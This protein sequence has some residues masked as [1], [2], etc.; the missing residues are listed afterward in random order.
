MSYYILFENEGEIPINAFK[1]L[2]ASSKR[3][4]DTKIG[5][6]G[7]GLKYAIALMLREGIDFKIFSGTKE[8]RIGKRQTKFLD[9]KIYVMTVNDEKTSITLDA[10][11]DW[12]PWFAIREIYSNTIDEGGKM[13]LN[14]PVEPVA[15][16]TRI[17]I[18]SANLK[19]TDIMASWGDFFTIGRVVAEKIE[20][21]P[22]GRILEKTETNPNFTVFRKGIRAYT[23][24]KQ[25]LFD[26]DLDTLDINESRV[27]KYSWQAETHSAKLLARATQ[28][29]V[30]RFLALADKERTHEFMEWENDF[31]QYCDIMFDKSWLVAI[32]DRMLIPANFA[33]RYDQTGATLVLPDTLIQKLKGSFGQYIRVV[34]E[35]QEPF[36]VA[37]GIDMQLVH[38]SIDMFNNAGFE[39]DKSDVMMAQFH[40]KAVLGCTS[41]NK[42]VL[43]TKLLE[44]SDRPHLDAAILEEYI[45]IKT[46]HGDNSRQMQTYLFQLIVTM[47]RKGAAV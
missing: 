44:D 11:I 27:A 31:W 10:G 25:S 24:N 40:D 18:D 33:G 36:T 22:S 23:Q 12:Q 6:Y 2:G 45:H 46:G 5:F 34:G 28:Q 7:T 39:I 15:G 3:N 35:D 13:Q 26:Y 41:G 38:Q 9:Q 30:S 1:L 32:N 21:S 17:Y 19:L 4:D 37:E 14:A 43:S 20:K 8:V 47:V 29:T 16:K 42:I